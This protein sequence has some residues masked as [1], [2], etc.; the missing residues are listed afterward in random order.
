MLL[1][2]LQHSKK[3]RKSAFQLKQRNIR[4]SFSE[5]FYDRKKNQ[6]QK[7]K[8]NLKVFFFHLFSIQTSFE[9]ISSFKKHFYF[10][11][12]HSL[13]VSWCQSGCYKII[14][15]ML[16]SEGW[17]IATHFFAPEG[18]PIKYILVKINHGALRHL[19]SSLSL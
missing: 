11:L 14:L 8:R 10:M 5:L 9:Y 17:K 2:Y 16:K 12:S 7:K 18:N 13:L 4:I 3:I 15:K 1:Q 19:N 6:I